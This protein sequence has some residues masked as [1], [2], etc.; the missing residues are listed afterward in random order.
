MFVPFARYNTF[1]TFVLFY[2][3]ALVR[4][5]KLARPLAV[6]TAAC[7]ARARMATIRHRPQAWTAVCRAWMT[8]AA[9]VANVARRAW[10]APEALYF[11]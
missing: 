9:R 6:G 5:Q 1:W 2:F 4:R 10:D 3:A 11:R 7:L 8:V